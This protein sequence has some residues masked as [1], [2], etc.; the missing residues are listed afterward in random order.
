MFGLFK[1]KA[2]HKGPMTDEELE[3]AGYVVIHRDNCT[4]KQRRRID[5]Y[6]IV[7]KCP[8]DTLILSRDEFEEE[9]DE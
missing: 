3:A 5:F 8:I 7:S 6:A 1:K 4:P 9:R 2:P